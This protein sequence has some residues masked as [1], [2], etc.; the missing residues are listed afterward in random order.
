MVNA[1]STASTTHSQRE[2]ADLSSK[3]NVLEKE[4]RRKDYHVV[5]IASDNKIIMSVNCKMGQTV[6]PKETLLII[7]SKEDYDKEYLENKENQ[8]RYKDKNRLKFTPKSSSKN[9][10]ITSPI[11]GKIEKIYVPKNLPQKAVAKA[12]VIV[13]KKGCP[14][15]IVFQNMC[16]MCG[17]N[18][19]PVQIQHGNITKSI[20]QLRT[21]KQRRSS[22][23]NSSKT[24]IKN[25]KNSALIPNMPELRVNDE[26]ALDISKQDKLRLH[27]QKKLVLLCDLDHTLIHTTE[28]N[29]SI[30]IDNQQIF[31]FGL[32]VPNENRTTT[33]T[34]SAKS[35]K[36]IQYHATKLR[37]N[38]KNFLNNISQKY[39]LYI[40]TLG[41]RTYA[42]EISRI[43][44]PE[45][46]YFS[47]SRMLSR[48]DL[49]DKDG[50]QGKNGFYKDNNL[51]HMFPCGEEMVTIIDDR[52][53]VWRQRHN[54]IHVPKY[55]YWNSGDINDPFR[56]KQGER[57]KSNIDM[58]ENKSSDE[59]EDDPELTPLPTSDTP[60]NLD[61]DDYLARLENLLYDIHARYY[62]VYKK[63]QNTSAKDK[64]KK[65]M[66][67]KAEGAINHIKWKI[68]KEYVFYFDPKIRLFGPYQSNIN[69]K[70]RFG[71]WK[72]D[73]WWQ[74]KKT[75]RGN[76]NSAV[77]LAKI[78][79][80]SLGGQI[81]DK[82]F[83]KC[84]QIT[85]VVCPTK[86][87]VDFPLKKVLESSCDISQSATT[88]T[89]DLYMTEVDP[90]FIAETWIWTCYWLLEKVPEQKFL[91]P[92]DL[93]NYMKSHKIIQYFQE[94][95][96]FL[97]W[98]KD[99]WDTS[100]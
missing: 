100:K 98:Q 86:G 71:D 50:E 44:D 85:H 18:T 61:Q 9:E 91:A 89:K 58:S 79:I 83:M 21:H 22:S 49:L 96:N 37:P 26:I 47:D 80:K 53:D 90:N 52:V 8:E 75:S 48:D 54:V 45:Q 74:N 16:T 41:V 60:Y 32:T 25:D 87:I 55:F 51:K 62:K 65:S 97:G 76:E 78:V 82:K 88:K 17:I 92:E 93:H 19:K 29:P 72:Y 63:Q 33:A 73:G 38:L 68:F 31:K 35:I 43:I 69:Y 59:G 3:E 56:T 6:R 66:L 20:H 57:D 67:P 34:T 24:N 36:Q 40:A 84:S 15:E 70:N 1:P 11:F 10:K 99:I 95:D 81:W 28:Y 12:P 13:I 64:I 14:H 30:K 23:V 27:H 46:K 7:K 94:F 5:R 39:E 4:V 2:M 42:Q 77:E